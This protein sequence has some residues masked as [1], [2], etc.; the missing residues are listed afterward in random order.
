[1]WVGKLGVKLYVVP[2]DIF[3]RSQNKDH[4]LGALSSLTGGVL[5]QFF[6]IDEK[7]IEGKSS[8]LGEHC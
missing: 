3:N 5:F 2:L 6:E 8:I 7:I 4:Q 1:M